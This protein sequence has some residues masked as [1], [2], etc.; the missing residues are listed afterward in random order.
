[1]KLNEIDDICNPKSCKNSSIQ[2][3]EVA[4]YCTDANAQIQN[5]C[6]L[7]KTNDSEIIGFV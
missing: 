7:N 5:R 2:S 1:M 3:N 6:C 4:K